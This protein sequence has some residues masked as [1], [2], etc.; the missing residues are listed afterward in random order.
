MSFDFDSPQNFTKLEIFNWECIPKKYSSNLNN[1]VIWKITS[2]DISVQI[3]RSYNVIPNT[4]RHWRNKFNENRPELFPK[5][6]EV[7]KLQQ[8][9]T[10]LEQL[11][12]QKQREGLQY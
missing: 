8:R 4:V 3:A 7:E 9:S 12:G 1:Q 2:E 6:E 11:L 5:C 10:E